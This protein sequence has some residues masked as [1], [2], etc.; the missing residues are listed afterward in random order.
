M[1]IIGQESHKTLYKRNDEKVLPP[2]DRR[3][4]LRMKSKEQYSGQFLKIYQR[5]DFPGDRI[6]LSQID[7]E[8]QN[9]TELH[10]DFLERTRVNVNLTRNLKLKK[11]GI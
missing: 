7:N 11:K 2:G 8:G 4:L 6:V 9:F 5:R 3:F 1:V 10:L